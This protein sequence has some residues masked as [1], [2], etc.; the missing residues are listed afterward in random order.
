[1]SLNT[2]VNVTIT[3]ETK[4]V[5]KKG[6]G[7]EY[8]AYLSPRKAITLKRSSNPSAWGYSYEIAVL[9]LDK[10]DVDDYTRQ[11]GIRIE[12]LTNK[13]TKKEFMKLYN[14]AQQS[15]KEVMIFSKRSKKEILCEKIIEK[16]EE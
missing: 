10:N 13:I 12:D 14:E 16:D 5:S 2:I 9:D 7:T 1:M 4:S 3:K 8:R 6:F 11:R 15:I